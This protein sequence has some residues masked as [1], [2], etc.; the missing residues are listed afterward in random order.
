MFTLIKGVSM[1]SNS[2]WTEKELE[3]LQQNYK[4][5]GSNIPELRETRSC[6]AIQ[7]QA[8][9]QGL[10]IREKRCSWTLEDIEILKQEYPKNGANIPQLLGRYKIESIKWKAVKLK[11]NIERPEWTANEIELLKKEF[12]TRGT[13]IAGLEHYSKSAI[14]SQAAKCDITYEKRWTP[15]RI[16]L[17]KKEYPKLGPNIPNITEAGFAKHAIEKMASRLGIKRDRSTIQ[18]SKADKWATDD[19]ETLKDQFPDQ[20]A[21]IPELLQKY[22][23]S[24]INAKARTLGFSIKRGRPSRSKVESEA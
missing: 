22:S 7:L 19:V 15:E 18:Y 6:A 11:L 23:K 5:K 14:Q 2:R 24:S 16:E 12:P 8:Q 20:G 3:I 1:E 9:K 10:R 4:E 21:A 13:K 17:L